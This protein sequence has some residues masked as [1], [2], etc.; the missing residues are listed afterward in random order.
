MKFIATIITFTTFFL[1]ST[2][3]V[4]AHETGQPHT[5]TPAEISPVAAIGI[6][7]V[8]SVGGFLLW[9]FLLNK[10]EPIQKK[11]ETSPP[12]APPPTQTPT[13]STQPTSDVKPE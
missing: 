5:E 7:L 4:Y 9:K 11:T 1:K 6:L 2:F 13:Q 12:S 10:K 8:L 3:V